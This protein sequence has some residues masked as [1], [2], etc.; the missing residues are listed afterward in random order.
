VA[1]GAAVT[2]APRFQVPI[3]H[4]GLEHRTGYQSNYL[5]GLNIPLPQR[6]ALGKQVTA[7]LDDGSDELKYHKF[8]VVMHKGRR[9]ALLTGANV[10]WRSQSRLIDGKKPSR[11]QLTGIPEGTLEEWV[12]DWRISEDHQLPDIFFTKDRQSFDKGHVVRRDDVA[13]GSTFEDMQMANGDT[14]HTP[15]CT[16]Q[17]SAFNQGSRGV[18]NWGDL[19]TLIQQETKAEKAI[20]FGG[21]VLASND[22]FFDGVTADGPIKVKIPRKF[23]KIVVVKD[24]QDAAAYGFVLKHDLS[25]V[26]MRV[27]EFTVPVTWQ[28]FMEPIEEIEKLLKGLATMDQLKTFDRFG[29]DESVRIQGQL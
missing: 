27:E 12:T 7:K 11:Q 9:L 19:E 26:Q 13:W 14:Y 4:D 5:D 21:P 18:D 8:S 3:I 6:T 22:P 16:P 29:A 28:R 17:T 15:N 20:V 23:W 10:D 2:E 1:A 25:D 24:G